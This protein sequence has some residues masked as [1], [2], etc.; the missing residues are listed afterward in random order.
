MKNRKLSKICLLTI[1]LAMLITAIVGISV[2]AE[3]APEAPEIVSKNVS[4]EGALHLYYAIP[5]TDAVTA[6]NTVV[7]VY[8]T[9]PDTDASAELIGTYSGEE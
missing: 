2:H 5:V 3:D 6:D 8:K 9:N 1:A 4:Y 7:N